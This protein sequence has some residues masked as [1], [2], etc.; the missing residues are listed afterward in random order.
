VQP[1]RPLHTR[2]PITRYG[3]DIVLSELLAILAG[4][5]AQRQQWNAS[6]PPCGAHYVD[7]EKVEAP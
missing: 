2:R 4:A 7:L 6:L 1:T 3:T 5:C